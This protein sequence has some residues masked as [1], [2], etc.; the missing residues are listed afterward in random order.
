MLAACLALA[1]LIGPAAR[2]NAILTGAEPMEVI[3]T[4][5]DLIGADLRGVRGITEQQVRA[6]AKVDSDT[7]FGPLK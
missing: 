6:V 4:G 2:C 5:A 1:A 7:K 3:L